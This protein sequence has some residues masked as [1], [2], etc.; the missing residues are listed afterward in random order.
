MLQVKD[1]TTGASLGYITPDP[2]YWTPILTSDI[3]AA[4][5]ITIELLSG[6]TQ[7]TNVNFETTDSRGPYF[8]PVAGR[9]NTSDDLAPDLFK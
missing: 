1:A 3:N 9:D 6:A 8:A 2:S 4:L 7:A 5:V